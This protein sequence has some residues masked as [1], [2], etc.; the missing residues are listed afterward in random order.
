MLNEFQKLINSTKLTIKKLGEELINYQENTLNILINKDINK[1]K[2]LKDIKNMN[3]KA[4]K[5]DNDI[6]KM[7]A[8]YQPEADIL[9]DLISMLKINDEIFKIY[10][11]IR[12]YTKTLK[13]EFEFYKNK[14]NLINMHKISLEALKISFNNNYQVMTQ[15]SKEINE[16]AKKYYPLLQKEILTALKNNKIN[17]KNI[18]IVNNIEELKKILE[19]T[20]NISELISFVKKGGRFKVRI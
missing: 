6:I 11:N 13:E 5:I 19:H 16:K 20:Q 17:I 2:S 12:S 8:L 18:K 3:T 15:K 4:N 9:R 1:F 7:F 10:K 14:K